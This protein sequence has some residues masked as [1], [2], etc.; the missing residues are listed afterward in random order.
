MEPCKKKYPELDIG[1]EKE[2]ENRGYNGRIYTLYELRNSANNYKSSDDV[3]YRKVTQTKHEK[4]YNCKEEKV[5]QAILKE[6]YG[7]DSSF[8]EKWEK[9]TSYKDFEVLVSN[10]GRIKKDK[11]FVT[12]KDDS[13]KGYLKAWCDSVLVYK[14]VAEAFYGSTEGFHIHHINKNG[15]DCRPENLILLK[16]Q[17]H[18]KVHGWPIG[19]TEKMDDI[20]DPVESDK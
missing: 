2:T 20:E 19:K 18:S 1:L 4:V 6:V 10:L 17:E 8:V 5:P 9:V 14:L 3:K 16:Q 12:Q 15:F 13:I 7:L 11:E